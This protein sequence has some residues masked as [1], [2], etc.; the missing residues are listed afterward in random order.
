[1]CE[2]DSDEFRSWEDFQDE[3]S[4]LRVCF[5]GLEHILIGQY[6]LQPGKWQSNF[7]LFLGLFDTAVDGVLDH[8]RMQQ[9]VMQ[10]YLEH[11]E[12]IEGRGQRQ[13]QH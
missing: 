5:E 13:A 10:M 7:E 1:M 3:L 11:I 8:M 9:G 2:P 6:G 4:R 12:M